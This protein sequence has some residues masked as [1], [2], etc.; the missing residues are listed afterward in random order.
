HEL[1]PVYSYKYQSIPGQKPLVQSD[2]PTYR[3][4]L[5]SSGIV[6][7]N[8]ESLGIPASVVSAFATQ[9]AKDSSTSKPESS[10]CTRPVWHPSVHQISNK[11][12][13]RISIFI[14]LYFLP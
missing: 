14:F 10:V 7:G 4:T 13:N 11:G 8:T 3:H 2:T 1:S 12:P 6:R 9:Y 5:S